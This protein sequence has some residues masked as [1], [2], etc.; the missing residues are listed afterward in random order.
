MPVNTTGSTVQYTG[1][2][3]QTTFPFTFPIGSEGDLVVKVRVTATGVTVT[4]TLTTHYTVTKSG[5]NFDNGGNVEMVSAPAATDTLIIARD[6]THTQST[7]LLYG[8]PHDSEAYENMVDR[9]TLMIQELQAQVDRCLKIP[10]S[11]PDGTTTE[12]V[13]SV[14][15]ASQY[16]GLDT[17][18]GVIAAATFAAF[19]VASA[20]MQTML[21]DATAAIARA[22]LGA[23]G[24][25]EWPSFSVNLGGS[26][27]DNI[28]GTDKIDW[29]TEVFD[30]H[31][32]FAAGKFTPS[33]EGKYL[34]IARILWLNFTANDNGVIW[35]YKNGAAFRSSYGEL[36]GST[37]SQ[38][39]SAIVGANGTT[40]YFEIFANNVSRDTA[41][42]DGDIKDTHWMGS[43]VG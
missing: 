21:D 27:Q 25:P 37:M 16:I 32:D 15:R 18:G 41:D 28:T 29:N 36:I 34:L 19:G 11:D 26:Q 42:I 31:G 6:T 17:D 30:T 35:I 20:F 24:S 2:A 10:G 9:N 3:E 43:R 38:T 12:L 4:Q 5:T 23:F 8:D 7:D 1:D 40:D 14:D 33:V 39:I 13:N 22:T